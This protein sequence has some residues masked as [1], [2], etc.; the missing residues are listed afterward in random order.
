MQCIITEKG[1][2]V[3]KNLNATF[4]IHSSQTRSASKGAFHNDILKKKR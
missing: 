4:C 1:E 2:T 3:V